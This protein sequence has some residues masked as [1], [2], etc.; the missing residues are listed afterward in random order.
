MRPMSATRSRRSAVSWLSLGLN[1]IE[2]I[3]HAAGGAQVSKICRFDEVLGNRREQLMRCFVLTGLDLLP[4]HAQ[5]ASQFPEARPLPPCEL[6]G[7]VKTVISRGGG[8]RALLEQ[9]L[10]FDAQELAH[11]PLF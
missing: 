10:A 8:A 9:Q 5:C 1:P 3:K 6:Q 11:V 2:R 4:R 7:L